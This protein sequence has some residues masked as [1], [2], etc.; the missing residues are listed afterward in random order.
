MHSLWK[1]FD[2]PEKR[3]TLGNYLSII[4]QLMLSLTN[5]IAHLQHENE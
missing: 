4:A 3:R 1:L 5:A 2:E